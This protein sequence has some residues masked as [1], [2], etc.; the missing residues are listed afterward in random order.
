MASLVLLSVHPFIFVSLLAS[1]FH[2]LLN[3][4]PPIVS[5]CSSL[6]L[7]P[8]KTIFGLPLVAICPNS[9][10]LLFIAV[11]E[12]DINALC[13]VEQLVEKVWKKFKIMIHKFNFQINKNKE[14][15]YRW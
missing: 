8:W 1:L 9:P 15:P 13:M 2:L 10:I 11:F 6:Y 4:F 5:R 7:C 14:T 12:Q 3:G